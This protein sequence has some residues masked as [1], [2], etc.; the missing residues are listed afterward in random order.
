MSDWRHLR[1]RRAAALLNLASKMIVDG[2]CREPQ[3]LDALRFAIL[4]LKRPSGFLA[5][6]GDGPLG[7]DARGVDLFIRVYSPWIPG[8]AFLTPQETE[9][10]ST[11][12]AAAE[13]HKYSNNSRPL[14]EDD[15]TIP[16]TRQPDG[17]YAR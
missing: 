17:Y 6:F 11:H 16:L 1:R 12:N 10:L 3:T 13:E 14:S 5:V 4:V 8:A 9:L 15:D 2:N 7:I